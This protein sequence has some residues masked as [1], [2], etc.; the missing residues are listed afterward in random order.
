MYRP[1]NLKKWELPSNYMG[2][3]W[4][5]YYC[6][7]GQ[8]RDSDC[9]ERSNFDCG[10]EQLGGELTDNNDLELVLIVRD[11]HWAVGWIEWIAIHKTAIEQLKIA[12]KIMS[13]LANY[14]VLNDEHFY[15]LESEEANRI[16]SDC[17]DNSERI[18]YIRN[19]RSEF[20]FND[21]SD[22]MAVAKGEYFNGYASELIS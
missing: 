7:L 8:H 17:F 16:W 13:D 6:F 21:Y 14:P 18:E 3:S 11:N 5:D 4:D 22:L 19:N 12:D 2:D 15:E 20:D 9:L 10:I 1:E